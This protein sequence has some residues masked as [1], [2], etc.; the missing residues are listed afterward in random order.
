MTVTAVIYQKRTFEFL[1]SSIIALALGVA[2]VCASVGRAV[3]IDKVR[4]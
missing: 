1:T 4:R 3:A 2:H